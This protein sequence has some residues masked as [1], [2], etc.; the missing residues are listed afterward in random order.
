MH[1]E[2]NRLMDRLFRGLVFINKDEVIESMNS[3]AEEMTGGGDAL[4]IQPR[5]RTY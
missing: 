2:M 5:R 4:S 1:E 3:C